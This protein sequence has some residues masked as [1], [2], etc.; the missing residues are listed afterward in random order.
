MKARAMFLGCALLMGLLMLNGIAVAG[1][2]T[3]H[4]QLD[5]YGNGDGSGVV[6]LEGSV[7]GAD[8]ILIYLAGTGEMLMSAGPVSPVG[9]KGSHIYC[10]L[11]VLNLEIELR[12]YRQSGFL[13][14]SYHLRSKV[15]HRAIG[16]WSW[17]VKDSFG[18]SVSLG[19]K[20]TGCYTFGNCE[21]NYF[22]G[23][24]C[25]PCRF[26]VCCDGDS[27]FVQCGLQLCP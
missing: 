26:R 3:G 1:G 14:E 12:K 7:E 17:N 22:S 6:L 8:A 2:V 21:G 5:G 10:D 4:F 9:D 20:S 25:D 16:E 23:P 18:I 15:S 19:Q 11:S 13:V 24:Y 27:G